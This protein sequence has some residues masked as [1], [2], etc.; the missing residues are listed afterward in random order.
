[1]WI[2]CA[3]LKGELCT[4]VIFRFLNSRNNT[5]LQLQF[6]YRLNTG[7]KLQ[8]MECVIRIVDSGT[9]SLFLDMVNTSEYIA[10][11]CVHSLKK[12]GFNFNTEKFKTYD[13][14]KVLKQIWQTNS[15]NPKAL[16]IIS[17]I[18]I[19]YQIFEPIIWNNLLKQMVNCQMLNELKPIVKIVSTN[20]SLV[21]LAGLVTAWEYIIRMP[22]KNIS[23]ERSHAQDVELCNVLFEL[24]SSPVKSKMNILDLAET[25]VRFGQIHI[26]AIFI[27]FCNDDQKGNLCKLINS[28]KTDS[29]KADIIELEEMGIYPIITKLVCRELNLWMMWHFCSFFLVRLKEI[30]EHWMDS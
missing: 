9:D 18:C 14:L 12:F 1:M 25:C 11:K 17:Y 30:I 7:R 2:Q 20:A 4:H 3:K 5:N 21:H 8:V 15:N 24:Q 29:L 19:S 6:L 10:L 13:K 16:D 26:G 27:A 22:L 28:R 23:H